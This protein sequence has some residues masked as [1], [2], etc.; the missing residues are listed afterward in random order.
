MSK[1]GNR[2]QVHPVPVKAQPDEPEKPQATSSGGCLLRLFWMLV[3]NGL[4]AGAA[5]AIAQGRGFRLGMADA[6][7]WAAVAAMLAARYVD[8]QRMGGQ[9][10]SGSPATMA[11]WRRYAVILPLVAATIWGLAHLLAGG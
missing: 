9:T 7:L 11:H 2:T 5:I 8:I 4:L 10:A 1:P 6:I 3:G